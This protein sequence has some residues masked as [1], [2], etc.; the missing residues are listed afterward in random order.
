MEETRPAGSVLKT[1]NFPP[2]ASSDINYLYAHHQF[3]WGNAKYST[4]TALYA[5]F[6]M[7]LLVL[8]VPILK[9]FRAG[10]AGLGLLGTASFLGKNIGVALAFKPG[11]YHV[12]QC[13]LANDQIL[14]LWIV[15]RLNPLEPEYFGRV[16]PSTIGQNRI[17]P[18][19]P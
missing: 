10:D 4:V 13:K 9:R 15:H 19:K 8:V 12:G 17:L 11:V 7:V 18:Q 1:V 2:S 14:Q 16:L 3:G 5:A 6:G